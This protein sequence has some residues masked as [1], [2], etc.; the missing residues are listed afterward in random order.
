MRTRTYAGQIKGTRLTP[1]TTVMRF[2]ALALTPLLVLI[3]SPG[4]TKLPSPASSALYEREVSHGI[5]PIEPVRG[6][7]RPLALKVE[8]DSFAC[9]MCHEG[10]AGDLNEAALEGAHQNITFD[11]GLNLRCLNCHNP[12]NSDAYVNHDGSEIP[13][14]QPNALCAKCHGPHFREWNLGVHGRINGVWSEDFGEQM[15]LACVQCHDPHKPAFDPMV[16]AE[17]PVLTRFQRTGEGA[18]GHAE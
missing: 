13:A 16:P 1:I 5:H 14:E 11:H 10:F 17:A 8:E 18:P 3:L 2:G 4:C 9:S 7:L 15:K 6:A 12:A